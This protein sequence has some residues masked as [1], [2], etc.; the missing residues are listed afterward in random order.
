MSKMQKYLKTEKLLKKK[1]AEILANVQDFFT[2][3]KASYD[4]SDKKT[5]KEN[6]ISFFATQPEIKLYIKEPYPKYEDRLPEKWQES[7]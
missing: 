5:Y 1:D 3:F 2:K 6:L 7:I 4:K